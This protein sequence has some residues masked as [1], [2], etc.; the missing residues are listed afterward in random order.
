M[1]QIFRHR[2][3]LANEQGWRAKRRTQEYV[4]GL[5]EAGEAARNREGADSLPHSRSH[6]PFARCVR[7]QA[8]ISR[9]RYPS[10]RGRAAVRQAARSTRY[11]RRQW[12]PSRLLDRRPAQALV[13]RADDRARPAGPRLPNRCRNLGVDGVAI[14]RPVGKGDPQPAG[15]ASDLLGKRPFRRRR[16]IGARCF[17]PM[18]R[19]QHDRAVAHA[20]AYDMT[21]GKPAPTFAA[22]GAE[23]IRARLGFIPNTPDAEA[24]MRIEPPPSLAWATGRIRAATAAAAP[25]EEPPDE[26]ARIPGVPR[27]GPNRRGLVVGN[28]PNSGLELFPKS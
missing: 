17:G 23:R 1:R 22:I 24:G 20:D 28:N 25:P 7:S 15:I 2:V 4:A 3:D 11:W 16:D 9:S 12:S 5:E 13:P 8:S 14:R 10:F 19:I 27:L 6:L 18:D 21:A 26:C